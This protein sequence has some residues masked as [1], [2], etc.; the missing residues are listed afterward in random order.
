MP[1]ALKRATVA[2]PGGPSIK[3]SMRMTSAQSMR[4]TMGE[5]VQDQA[6]DMTM[7]MEM[8]GQECQVVIGRNDVDV[9]GLDPRQMGGLAHLE[10]GLA[11]QQVN[12]PQAN[13]MLN[14]VKDAPVLPALGARAPSTGAAAP[15]PQATPT[16][17]AGTDAPA[18]P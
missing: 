2:N 14:G 10:I 1:M 4:F 15:A 16:A 12:Q 18:A 11:L 7:E 17:P 5:M 6:V 13:I 8:A 3:G 9:G